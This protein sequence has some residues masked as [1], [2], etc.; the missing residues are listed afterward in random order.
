[1]VFDL[2]KNTN[3]AAA[4]VKSTP[5]HSILSAIPTP[6]PPKFKSAFM[7]LV[8]ELSGPTRSRCA[9]A[10]HSNREIPHLSNPT[11]TAIIAGTLLPP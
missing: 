10:S 11:I 8:R 3:K 5:S 7:I 2:Q 1:M 6:H 9:P 4:L